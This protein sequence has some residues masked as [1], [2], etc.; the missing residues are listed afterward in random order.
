M[1]HT[2]HM[3][4]LR[5]PHAIA[6]C[7]D[8]AA[9]QA[10]RAPQ[11]T[12]L[13]SGGAAK[14]SAMQHRLPLRTALPAVAAGMQGMIP[15]PPCIS[16]SNFSTLQYNVR[17]YQACAPRHSPASARVEVHQWLRERTGPQSHCC[18][19]VVSCSARKGRGASPATI[20]G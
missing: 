20:S 11:M 3:V 17:D 12:G 15:R 19:N 5:T 18:A 14:A 4:L 7:P 16:H 1:V 6:T 9:G 8:Q 2:V 13:Q 10:P